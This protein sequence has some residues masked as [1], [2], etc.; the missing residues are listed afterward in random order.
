VLVLEMW[1]HRPHQI[2]H[3]RRYNDNSRNKLLWKLKQNFCT[4]CCSGEAVTCSADVR[5]STAID[6]VASDTDNVQKL[7]MFRYCQLLNTG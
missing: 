1:W 2:K 4:Q 5:T 7:K 6:C 3:L